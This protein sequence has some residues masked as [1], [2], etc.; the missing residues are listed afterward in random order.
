[1]ETERKW[2]DLSPEERREERFKR[3]LLPHDVKF[4]SAEAEEGYKERVTRFIKVIKLEEPDR[5]PVMLPAGFFPATYAGST[6]KKVMYDYDELRRSWL[7]FLHDFEL[8]TFSGPVFTHPGKVFDILDYKLQQWPGHG[9]PENSSSYQYVEGEYMFPEEYD[10]L[11]KDPLDYLI[12]TWLP[13]TVGAF[14]AFRKLGQVPLIEYLPISY[15][16]Q[17][18]DPEVRASVLALLDAAQEGAKWLR[19]VGDVSRIVRESGVP[20]LLGG[21]S[22]APFDF[23]GDSLRGTKGVMLDMYKRPE[24]LQEAMERVTPIIIERT[25]SGADAAGSPVVIFT[26]HKGPGGFMSNKQFE[27]FY[28]PSLKKVMMGLIDQGLVPMPFAEGDYIPRLEI[29]KDMPRGAVIWYF[30]VM[31]MAKAKKVLGDNACIAGNLPASILCTGTP[32]QVKESCRQLI[33][34][35]APGGGYILAGGAAIDEGNPDNLRAVMEAAKEYGVYKK[36]IK[37]NF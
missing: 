27:T 19:A 24:K 23:L 7:I 25:V 37:N 26:L 16:T 36:S 1:M 6:L 11:I 35:C 5:V 8:D 28:W 15:I 29:I 32:H 31:D 18:A 17:F 20:S 3:W 34:T 2:A 13:R 12:R 21:R 33:E 9:L 22:R 4:S 10:A 30:E 14:G